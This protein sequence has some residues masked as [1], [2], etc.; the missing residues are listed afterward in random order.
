M[1]LVILSNRESEQTTTAKEQSIFKPY[2]FRND[3]S[4]QLELPA[5]CQVALQSVKFTLDGTIAVGS[6]SL[7]YLYF[8]EEITIDENMDY[9]TAWPIRV[10]VVPGLPNGQIQY[11]T[12]EEFIDK[13]QQQFNK[14]VFHPNLRD[15]VTVQEKRNATTSALE[16]VE[17]RF[18]Q[19]AG[20]TNTIPDA[21]QEFSHNAFLTNL[22]DNGGAGWEYAAGSF[23]TISSSHAGFAPAQALLTGA[24][25]ISLVNGEMVVDFSGAGTGGDM[26][27]WGI[28]LSRYSQPAPGGRFAPI[29]YYDDIN[30]DE[31]PAAD[32]FSD[33][34]VVCRNH[35]LKLCNTSLNTSVD[36]DAICWNNVVYDDT[37]GSIPADYNLSTNASSFTKVKFT[38]SGQQIKVEMLQAD[39]TAFLL[40]EYDAAFGYDE[41]LKPVNQACWHMYPTLHLDRTEN[42]YGENLDITSYTP[43][44]NISSDVYDGPNNSWFNSVQQT[45][46]NGEA[47]AWDLERRPWN[48]ADNASRGNF[49]T[50]AAASVGANGRIELSNGVFTKPSVKYVPT[51][52]AN[53][54]QIFGGFKSTFTSAAHPDDRLIES[55][56]APTLISSKSM[57]VRLDNFTGQST[58]GFGKNK[59]SIIAHVPRF[60]S[61]TESVRIYHEPNELMY[62]DLHNPSPIRI[63]SFDV[64]FCHVNEQ[65]ATNMA[66]QTIVCLHFREKPKM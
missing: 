16:G 34:M 3:L 44:T 46:V 54:R 1:S 20:T 13:V 48:D 50:Q 64:S 53:T 11:L 29:Y 65:Y 62:I 51:T 52:G 56:S 19:Y 15:L 42:N 40:Y 12:Y 24:G 33:Y 2:A 5:N 21:A 28:G 45:G 27:D 4:S 7:V 35:I 14:F 36:D 60:D 23:T 31:G 49:N 66:G 43:C 6:H 41:I 30:Q 57:F 22:S 61:S 47:D 10:P 63:S 37:N 17:I 39:D 55:V 18:G 32:I 38:T 59:S 9:S 58:N 8:G 25:P 26:V